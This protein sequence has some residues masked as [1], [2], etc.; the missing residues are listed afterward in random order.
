MLDN[1]AKKETW[2]TV[3]FS[4]L[5]GEFHVIDADKTDKYFLS[6][7]NDIELLPDNTLNVYFK[8]EK[9]T[10]KGENGECFYFLIHLHKLLQF[11]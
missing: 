11:S 5:F 2:K 8:K 6:N 7:I 3:T 9:L 1:T 10:F 4:I